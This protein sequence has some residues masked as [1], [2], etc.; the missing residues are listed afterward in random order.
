MRETLTE[1]RSLKI[2]SA[3][4]AGLKS[5]HDALVKVLDGDEKKVARFKSL[6]VDHA[7][8]AARSL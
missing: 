4:I 7:I 2:A 8:K 3:M 5:Q 6:M 1:S